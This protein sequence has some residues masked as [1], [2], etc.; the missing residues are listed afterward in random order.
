MSVLNSD[1]T[2]SNVQ[3]AEPENET[4]IGVGRLFSS[5]KSCPR[6]DC[7]DNFWVPKYIDLVSLARS[8]MFCRHCIAHGI[9]RSNN[10]PAQW[11]C[12][13]TVVPSIGTL[14]PQRTD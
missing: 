14:A 10:L 4:Q 3:P 13:A 6:A 7:D 2:R 5:G 12:E 8:R 11:L 9:N 1:R